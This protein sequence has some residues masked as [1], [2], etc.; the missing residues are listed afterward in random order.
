[1]EKRK[2]NWKW[3]YQLQHKEAQLHKRL[4]SSR[5]ERGWSRRKRKNSENYNNLLPWWHECALTYHQQIS[6]PNNPKPH[7]GIL[8]RRQNNVAM[9]QYMWENWPGILGDFHIFTH[10]YTNFKLLNRM[11]QVFWHVLSS[12]LKSEWYI[13]V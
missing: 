4:I 6:H 13:E 10:V 2:R 8:S 3:P 7:T 1:M 12:F 11:F 5:E 9:N